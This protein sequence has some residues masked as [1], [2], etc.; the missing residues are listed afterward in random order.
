MSNIQVS[1]ADLP[2][3]IRER[4]AG[5]VEEFPDNPVLEKRLCDL[6]RLTWSKAY[7]AGWEDRAGG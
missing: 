6:A 5:I 7:R 1:I 2:P 3:A 4:V